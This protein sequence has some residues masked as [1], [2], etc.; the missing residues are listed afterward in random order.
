MGYPTSVPSFTTKQD[1]VD[2]PQAAHVN[3]LQTEVTAI[4]NALISG[5][6]HPVTLTSTNGLTVGGV[7]SGVVPTVKLTHSADQGIASG[8]AY[9]GLNWDTESLD[10]VGMHS[11]SANSSRIT[12]ASATGW[13][14][15]GA[16]IEWNPNSSGSRVV[17]LML[18][19]ITGI[20]G[21]ARHASTVT[22]YTTN[23]PPAVFALVVGLA[24]G[25]RRSCPPK[26]SRSD[27]AR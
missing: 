20:A 16:S 7:I 5:I 21:D 10:N 11:T 17:R 4:A 14:A 1:G 24:S 12:F 22:A 8:N 25:K 23:Q 18:N 19:D 15:V 6:A 26:P 9:T 13:Y 27:S 3:D 2:Y